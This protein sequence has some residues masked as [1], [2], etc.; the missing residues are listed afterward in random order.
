PEKIL[1]LYNQAG[2]VKPFLFYHKETGRTSTFESV[3]FP[4]W[5]I[6]SSSEQGQ[7][8]ILTSEQG[9]THNTA[10]DLSLQEWRSSLHSGSGKLKEHTLSSLSWSEMDGEYGDCR[11]DAVRSYTGLVFEPTWVNT[12]DTSHQVCVLQGKTLILLAVPRKR[13]VIPATIGLIPCKY[14]E[15]FETDKGNP[16]YPGLKELGLCLLCTA[17]K[18]QPSLQLQ[19]ESMVDLYQQTQPQRAFLFYLSQNGSTSSFE[20]VAFPGWFIAICAGG[21][22][23]PIS[24]QELGKYTALTLGSYDG[25]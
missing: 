2:P 20:S 15:T 11:L 1:D 5:F 4:G 8:I 17:L 7:P 9:R 14:Q 16:I 13:H 21:G 12:Q 25:R 19:E 22:S 24:T 18:G 6:A 3:A 23:P 10:F